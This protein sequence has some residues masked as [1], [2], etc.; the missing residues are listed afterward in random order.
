M[1]HLHT[2]EMLLYPHRKLLKVKI[3][4]GVA[5]DENNYD[6]MRL[7]NSCTVSPVSGTKGWHNNNN[8]NNNKRVVPMSRL[9]Q[10]Q[11]LLSTYT[12]S[13]ETDI[14]YFRFEY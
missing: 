9:F 4:R 3:R 8:S 1:R 5:E 2:Q 13:N 12:T 7:L 10:E 11:V 14:D 6:N